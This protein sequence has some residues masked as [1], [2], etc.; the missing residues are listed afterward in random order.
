MV[1]I[2]SSAVYHRGTDNRRFPLF[3]RQRLV[4]L[5]IVAAIG[6]AT[7]VANLQTTQVYQPKSPGERLLDGS[8]RIVTYRLS[9]F[10]RQHW[11]HLSVAHV[12][13]HPAIRPYNHSE[14]IKQQWSFWVRRLV[15]KVFQ[16][17]PGV[18]AVTLSVQR[19]RLSPVGV[20]LQ[21]NEWKNQC[22][23]RD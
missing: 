15:Q 1:L 23:L 7:R 21:C 14:L 13:A 4:W 16:R 11:T 3:L 18:L 9:P 10:A 2:V 12:L 19:K 5:A 17:T 22:V 6:R 8:P 20:I